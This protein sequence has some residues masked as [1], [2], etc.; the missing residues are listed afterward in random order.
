MF[1]DV[2]F[3]P[4][5]KTG[6]NKFTPPPPQKKPCVLR[7]ITGAEKGTQCKSDA[8]DP[9]FLGV[10]VRDLASW[11]SWLPEFVHPWYG[12]SNR[13]PKSQ[14]HST[15]PKVYLSFCVPLVYRMCF[16]IS[17]I[18]FMFIKVL[19]RSLPLLIYFILYRLYLPLFLSIVTRNMV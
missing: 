8:E 7:Q 5:H 18:V 1:K 16:G 4:S 14:I 13:V 15:T 10:T 6:A 19:Y 12:P 2:F 11:T 9:K 17:S 3:T